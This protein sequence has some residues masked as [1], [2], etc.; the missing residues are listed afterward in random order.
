MINISKRLLTIISVGSGLIAIILGLLVFRHN[1]PQ[2]FLPPITLE[3]PSDPF[4]V[5]TI[6]TPQ[7]EPA[8]TATIPVEIPRS[9]SKLRST[10]RPDPLPTATIPW[11]QFGD[12]NILDLPTV[13]T[14][15]PACK[16]APIT[17]PQFTVL[18]WTPGLLE[19]GAFNVGKK[20]VV[21]WEHLGFTGYWIHSGVDW[22]GKPLAAFPL[23]DYLEKIN[24][25]KFRTPEEFNQHATDC[26]IGSAVTLKVGDQTLNGKVTAVLRVPVTEMVAVSSHV[27]DLVPYLA[28]TY[29]ESGFDKLQAPEL[30][31][32]F[33]G[34]RLTTEREDPTIE[35]YAQ[36]RIIVTI[37]FD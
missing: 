5:N 15:Q 3:A 14:F 37:D 7:P 25:W 24:T 30:L 22:L 20:T 29:P 32:Y 10:A 2:V 28:K 23:Q 12:V 27:M 34:R 11:M 1:Q 13:M 6:F 35:Y 36:S 4:L 19:S 8:P 33:C 26:V 31:L 17:L 21:A 9:A 18:P 16:T